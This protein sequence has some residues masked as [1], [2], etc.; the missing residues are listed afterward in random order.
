MGGNYDSGLLKLV[1]KPI[2]EMELDSLT[3]Y[4]KMLERCRKLLEDTW[5]SVAMLFS[6][7]DAFSVSL[8]DGSRGDSLNRSNE[9]V[10]QRVEWRLRSIDNQIQMS[11][12]TIKI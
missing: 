10:I 11:P 7:V 4:V 5:F 6:V 9:E 2:I 12:W 3:E 8:V 1:P